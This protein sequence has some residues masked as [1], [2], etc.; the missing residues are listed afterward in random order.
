MSEISGD[1]TMSQKSQGQNRA[2]LQNPFPSSSSVVIK[3][4]TRRVV[5]VKILQLLATAISG[6]VRKKS[7]TDCQDEYLLTFC[8][9]IIVHLP[10]ERK[11][12]Q[13]ELPLRIPTAAASSN[14]ASS[15][16]ASSLA[17]VCMCLRYTYTE[18][19]MVQLQSSS[20]Q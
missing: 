10:W 16:R 9:Y 3:I 8:L 19:T 4:D 13:E 1:K 14:P 12:R 7:F 5:T 11:G 18:S 2:K 15:K 20:I 6:L 17:S